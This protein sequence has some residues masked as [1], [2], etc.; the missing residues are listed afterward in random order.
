M[1]RH[2]LQMR[3][4]KIF[5]ENYFD[6]ICYTGA[7]DKTAYDVRDGK[8]DVGVINRVVMQQMLSDGRLQDSDLRIVWETPP[9]PDYVWSVHDHI[10]QETRTKISN[11]FLE[12][13]LNDPVSNDI[14]KRLS[15]H[16]YLPARL[17]TFKPLFDIAKDSGML[18]K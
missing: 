13:N 14:L 10:S 16:Y 3:Q 7:H 1:P 4:D 12:L 11:A 2:F 6:N 8:A 5:P 9:Y 18:G 17:K 15:A